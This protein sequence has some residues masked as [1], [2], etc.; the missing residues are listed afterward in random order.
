MK[1]LHQVE[2]CIDLATIAGD[3]D[4]DHVIQQSGSY[5][6]SCDLVVTNPTAVRVTVNDVTIDLRGVAG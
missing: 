6:L 3:E 5:Y 4:A 1:S 2:P